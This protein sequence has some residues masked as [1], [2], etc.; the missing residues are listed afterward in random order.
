MS[1]SA[2]PI[3]ERRTPMALLVRL[4]A[5]WQLACLRARNLIKDVLSRSGLRTEQRDV[6]LCCERDIRCSLIE[7][8]SIWSKLALRLREQSSVANPSSVTTHAQGR[9]SASTEE[10]HPRR[11]VQ[12]TIA[13]NGVQNSSRVFVHIVTFT[14]LS[15]RF[16][17][18]P[19]M[20]KATV[21]RNCS[22]S[23]NAKNKNIAA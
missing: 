18:M 10:D 5:A 22:D 11:D 7:Y 15:P 8:D 21:L 2:P 19:K 9:A 13:A 3:R 14:P 12:C 1:T 6:R 17:Y 16:P 23:R 4:A 20:P